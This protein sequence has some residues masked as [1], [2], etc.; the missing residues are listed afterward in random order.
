M[1]YL[2]EKSGKKLSELKKLYQL[3]KD[4]YKMYGASIKLQ[5]ALGIRWIDH[6][7]NSMRQLIDKY[8]LY[9]SHLQYFIVD[10]STS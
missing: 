4:E 7:M 5:W 2:Y 3:L 6:K 9:V 1:Y 8:G 10:T